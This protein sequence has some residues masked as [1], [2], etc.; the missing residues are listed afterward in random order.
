MQRRRD[1]FVTVGPSRSSIA[2]RRAGNAIQ[3]RTK[4]ADMAERPKALRHIGLLVTEP[5]GPAELLFM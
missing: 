2:P 1:V 5:P 3:E 4:K